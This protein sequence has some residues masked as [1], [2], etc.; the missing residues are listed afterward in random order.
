MTPTSSKKPPQLP[1]TTGMLKLL[2]DNLDLTQPMDATIA[3]C[4]V[5]AFWR[6]CCLGKLLSSSSSDLS[7]VSKPARSH[8]THSLHSPDSHTIF[9]P[10]TKIEWDGEKIILIPQSKELDPALH[11]KS[12]LAMSK[13]TSHFP[14]LTFSTPS[15][16][17]MLTKPAF[18]TRCNQV[19]STLG[20]PHITGHSFHIGGTT[21]FLTTGF[22]P[23]VIKIMSC[24]SSDS[25]LH[26]WR[27]LESI[28]PLHACK[29]HHQKLCCQT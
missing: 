3:A 17:C 8:L 14:L 22:P 19:W 6:Q 9:L 24:W 12:H 7:T 21:E 25:F 15:G 18:L 4:A 11:L 20:Y 13:L 2:I 1:I 29:I 23:D 27:D 16:P 26:Y 28:A 10:W 5:L